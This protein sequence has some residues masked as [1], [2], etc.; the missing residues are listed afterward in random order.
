MA[1]INFIEF[2]GTLDEA[3]TERTSPQI[4]LYE[5][6]GIHLLPNNI[7]P[8]IQ[9][10]N[11]S[12]GIELEDWSAYIVNTWDSS[13]TDI[14]SYF[15]IENVFTDDNGNAQ[16]TWSLTN[17]PFDFGNKMVYLKVSQT[18][19]ET[20][21]S[22]MFQFTENN[23][24]KTIRIDYRS[25]GQ[26]VMQSIQLKM[27]YWQTLK[28]QELSTYY[29]T[30]TRNTVTNVV[31]SQTY[32]KWLTNSI[33]NSLFLKISD[34][35]EYKYVYINLLRC[36]LFENIEIKEH[37]GTQ[38]YASNTLNI[39]FNKSEVYNPLTANIPVVDPLVPTI[40]LNSIIV[41]GINAI[42]DFSYE[43]FVPTYLVFEYSQDQVT[44]TSNT[45]GI[46]SKKTIPFSG[47]GTWYFRINHPLAISNVITLDL[48]SEVIANNDKINIEKGGTIDINVL[49][50]DITVGNTLITGVGL[51]IN[52]TVTIIDGG[53]KLR[54]I[55]NDSMTISDTFTYTISN[56]ITTDTGTVTVAIST[57][58]EPAKSFLTN[59][60]GSLDKPSSCFLDLT[61]TR[62]FT[63]L[64]IIPDV[65]DT[66]YVDES[67][68]TVFNGNNR[69]YPIIFGGTI[70]INNLGEVL[71]LQP[72]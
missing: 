4:N 37:S 65:G 35:F 33:S 29:E 59:G 53:T 52:G 46:I 47:T 19:G 2:Y 45:S 44:W 5:V 40:T 31:K 7:Y 62:Y 58:S 34:V 60:T 51:P 25:N 17:V 39:S 38:N 27:W 36:N 66:V 55:H 56:G 57:I 13:E 61:V 72:C 48:G 24:E 21:Y 54:Y 32:E 9:T 50:N 67:L 63:G 43:N 14:T 70:Q 64:E 10:T 23:S 30:S 41:N 15:T 18:I 42:Y 71:D 28:N 16:F 22:N 69:W 3:L 1:D 49:S 12:S 68:T 20:F 8:Y 26:D 6:R 11:V